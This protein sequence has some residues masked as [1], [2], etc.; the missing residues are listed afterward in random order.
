VVTLVVALAVI[1]AAVVLLTAIGAPLPRTTLTRPGAREMIVVGRRVGPRRLV[2]ETALVVGAVAG[3]VLLRD[4]GL[5]WATG[6]AVA[7][8]EPVGADPL[9]VAVPALLGL[10]AGVITLRGYPLLTSLVARLAA[11]R[12]GLVLTLATRRAAR[13]RTS[14]AVLLTLVATASVAGFACCRSASTRPPS[15]G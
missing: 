11:W 10:A 4:R 5:A 13:G 7:G 15:R 1:V 6:S 12:R 8:G 14:A 9:M 3:A 2:V